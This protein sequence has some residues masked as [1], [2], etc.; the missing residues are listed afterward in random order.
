MDRQFYTTRRMPAPFNAKEVRLYSE[1]LRTLVME[2]L[3]YLPRNRP[4]LDAVLKKIRRHTG[5]GSRDLA[6]GLRHA[7]A[8]DPG[9]TKFGLLLGRE[10]WPLRSMLRDEP[11]NPRDSRVAR[12]PTRKPKRDE[13]NDTDSSED[14][15]GGDP[16]MRMLFNPASR[17]PTGPGEPP[18]DP[19]GGLGMPRGHRP[20][21]GPL[22]TAAGA[23]A[24]GAGLER[25]PPVRNTPKRR[26]GVVVDLTNDSASSPKRARTEA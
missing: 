10:Q 19:L 20:S 17:T 9:F 2:C 18:Q 14:S 12:P 1:D 23:N 15:L 22:P 7:P 21:P 4:S 6:R 16:T 13:G 5:S 24:G 3:E 8:D 11:A 26:Q 25:S